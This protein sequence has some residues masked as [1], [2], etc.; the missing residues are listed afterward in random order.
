MC[1]QWQ[2]R[3]VILIYPLV[4]GGMAKSVFVHIENGTCQTN[5]CESRFAMMRLTILRAQPNHLAKAKIYIYRK[6]KLNIQQNAFTN[7]EWTRSQSQIF[8]IKTTHK[9]DTD[10]M[11]S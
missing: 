11:T 2:Y 9:Q 3:I 7:I 4:V 8:W 5:K 6:F 10:S 1:K